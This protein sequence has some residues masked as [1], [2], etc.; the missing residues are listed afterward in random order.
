LPRGALRID[1]SATGAGDRTFCAVHIPRQKPAVNARQPPKSG[2][3]TATFGAD[4]DR[5]FLRNRVDL[6]LPAAQRQGICK[7][8]GGHASESLEVAGL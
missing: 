8:N 3:E 4:F 6:Q 1:S 7:I 5:I 2:H